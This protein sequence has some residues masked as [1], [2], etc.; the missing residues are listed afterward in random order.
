MKDWSEH[1]RWN[2]LGPDPLKGAASGSRGQ[3]EGD[4]GL[5]VTVAAV[6]TLSFSNNSQNLLL[7]DSTDTQTSS[8]PEIVEVKEK[9]FEKNG[10][11]P[12]V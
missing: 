12:C 3:L 4:F 5:K 9:N 10:H 1:G 7:T 8:H 11:D 2:L 6:Q